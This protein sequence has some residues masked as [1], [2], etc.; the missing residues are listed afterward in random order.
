MTAEQSP[1]HTPV[2]SRGAGDAGWGMSQEEFDPSGVAQRQ[3]SK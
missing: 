1:L 2:S 3:A